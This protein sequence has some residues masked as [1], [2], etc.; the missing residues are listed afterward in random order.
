MTKAKP[1][2]DYGDLH[3]YHTG[4]YIRPATRDE[5]DASYAA[6]KRDGGAG[7]ISLQGRRVYVQD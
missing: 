3:D 4:E 7:V 5:R 2:E 6:A 1:Q